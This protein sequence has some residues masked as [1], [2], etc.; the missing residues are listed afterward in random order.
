MFPRFEATLK[1]SHFSVTKSRS[2]VFDQLAKH[3][4]L[5]VTKLAVYCQPQTDR[6]TVYRTVELFEQ[7]GIV[8][9]I[10][11]GFKSQLELS[12]IFTPHH[13]HAQCQQC[14]KTIDL[15]SPELESVLATLS[16]KHGFLAVGHVIELTGYCQICQ[17]K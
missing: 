16:K 4:P 12:E 2:A 1:K 6:A 7:L 15:V 5:P 3:G 17:H 14:G 10:W 8:N 13:H 9:R 11:H